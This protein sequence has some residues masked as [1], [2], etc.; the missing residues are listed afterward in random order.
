MEENKFVEKDLAKYIITRYGTVK[1]FA[2]RANLPY[3][4]VYSMLS[5]GL[6]K[7]HYKNV[8]QLCTALGINKDALMDDGKIIPATVDGGRTIN[9]ETY[10]DD[11]SPLIHS[12]THNLN[13][14]G[15]LKLLDYL[16]DLLANP[17]Y[18]Q[19]DGTK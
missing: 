14:A 9:I 3:T 18:T 4:T 17:K 2:I 19:K 1:D 6:G 15:R 11:I 12:W 8:S 16:D 13:E 10:G 7:A 5:R